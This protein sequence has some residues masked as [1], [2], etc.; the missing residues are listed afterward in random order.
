MLEEAPTESHPYQPES[1]E[2]EVD[3]QTRSEVPRAERQTKAAEPKF[4]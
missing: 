1:P 2:A 4:N 3:C